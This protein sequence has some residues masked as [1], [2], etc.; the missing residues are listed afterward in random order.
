MRRT[1]RQIKKYLAA[2]TCG[3]VETCGL[4]KAVQRSRR[5]LY[6]SERQGVL[7]QREFL[8]QQGRYIK[9]HWWLLQGAIL[10][11]L[12]L[13]LAL[14]HSGHYMQRYMGIAASLFGALVLPELWK[15]RSAGAMEIEG[16]AYFSLRQVYAARI[17]LFALVDFALLCV[18][19]LGA[20][21]GGVVA[22]GDL[23]VQFF[24]PYVVT[25]CIC[26]KTL[27]SP[28]IDSE[29]FALFLCVVWSLVWL[30]I[31]SEE[32]I[33]RAV[34][35]PVWLTMLGA[36]SVYLGYCVWRGQ[37]DCEN[38]LEVKTLWNLR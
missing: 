33:Y 7:S 19:S 1:D 9:K 21:F 35:L 10:A 20:L 34:S 15:N 23:L 5:A 6:E 37:R 8:Y 22:V 16:A 18:F 36:A 27:Y 4:G 25:C 17:F 13:L 11:A 24:L 26:F 3:S 28:R 31:L 29:V 38:L 12:W 30:M 2:A 14:T 32:K